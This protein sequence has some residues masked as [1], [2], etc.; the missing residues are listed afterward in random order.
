M[1]DPQAVMPLDCEPY[2]QGR[3]NTRVDGGTVLDSTAAREAGLT[4]RHGHP[5]FTCT[6]PR[7]LELGRGMLPRG[8][9]VQVPVLFQ[10]S[11]AIMSVFVPLAD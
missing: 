1:G 2:H 10:E 6:L 7:A 11:G 3:P 5:A 9:A 4:S 8:R